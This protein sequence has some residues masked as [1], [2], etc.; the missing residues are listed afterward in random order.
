MSSHLGVSF[1]LICFQR[2]SIPNLATQQCTWRY[3]WYTRG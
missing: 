2:L 3:N 1:A